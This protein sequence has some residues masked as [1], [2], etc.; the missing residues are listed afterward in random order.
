MITPFSA[1]HFHP[2]ITKAQ[3]QIEQCSV[4]PRWIGLTLM[5]A[6]HRS[7][8]LA[9]SKAFRTEIALLLYFLTVF[10]PALAAKALL[11]RLRVPQLAT[12]LLLHYLR[13][14]TS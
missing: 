12:T 6:A 5:R 11:S 8:G 2:F 4:A 9:Q 13:P 10:L 3:L 1:C 14:R 7:L